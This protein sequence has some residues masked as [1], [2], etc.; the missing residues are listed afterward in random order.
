MPCTCYMQ[1]TARV[2]H[3][4]NACMLAEEEFCEPLPRLVRSGQACNADALLLQMTAEQSVC[5]TFAAV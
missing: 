5:P 2:E 4:H 3:G 1:A